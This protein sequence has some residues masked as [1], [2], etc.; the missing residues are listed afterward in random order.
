MGPQTKDCPACM[1]AETSDADKLDDIYTCSRCGRI[2][3]L[4]GG[5]FRWIGPWSAMLPVCD[6]CL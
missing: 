1:R 6:R 3:T 2:E 4:R 5:G